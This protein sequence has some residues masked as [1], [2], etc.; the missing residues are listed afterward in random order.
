MAKG[1]RTEDKDNAKEETAI[2]G[3]HAKKKGWREE[4][5]HG[6]LGGK[7]GLNLGKER[8][9][10]NRSEVIAKTVHLLCSKSDYAGLRWMRCSSR[11]LLEMRMSPR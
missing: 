10:T 6:V 11:V 1:Q 7:D 5:S 2:K 8:R 4:R 9:K 3:E